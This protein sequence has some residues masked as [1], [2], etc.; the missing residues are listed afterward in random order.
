MTGGVVGRTLD[1]LVDLVSPRTALLRRVARVRSAKL[2]AYEAAVSDRTRAAGKAGSADGDLLPDLAKIRR[3]C[4]A[5]VRDDPHARA[6]MSVLVENV[7]GCGITVQAAATAEGTGATDDVVQKWNAEC[8][9]VWQRWCLDEA[10]ASE[11]QT[12]YELQQLVM[13]QLVYDGEALGHRVLVDDVPGRRLQTAV[14][15]IDPD[16]LDDVFGPAAP[17][18]NADVRG[19]VELGKR[20]QPVAYWISPFHPDD[21]PLQRSGVAGNAAERIERKKGETW[22]LVHVFVRQRPGQ[23][24]GVPLMTA[25]VP[26]FDH[27]KGYFDAELIGARAAANIAVIVERPLDATDPWITPNVGDAGDASSGEVQYHEAIRPGSYEYLNRGEKMTAF[28][29]SRPGQQF[30]PFVQRILRAIGSSMG[31]PYEMLARDFRGMNYS[32]ARVALLEARR[33]FEVLQDL[34]IDHWCR[35]W[36]ETVITEA[37]LRGE[38]KAPHGWM[39]DPRAWLASRCTAPSWGYVDPTKEIDAAT[40]AI[41]SNLS[42]P[43]LEAMRSGLDFEAVV[44]QRARAMVLLRDTERRYGLPEG[45]LSAAAGAPAPTPPQPPGGGKQEPQEQEEEAGG[46]GADGEEPNEEAA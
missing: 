23:T 38:L 28:N 29:P 15:L 26:F 27:L 6:A 33:G 40:S 1:A 10:D 25:S 34:L 16:R 7:V 36:Y 3:N 8:E 9:A 22:N 18:T 21:L 37:V 35:P 20:G 19:G 32:N 24:R 41:A 17:R 2:L 45:S 31:L 46:D 13:R 11:T 14:E 39:Q 4:R 30:D 44:E 42:T 5:L 43:Q 12:F